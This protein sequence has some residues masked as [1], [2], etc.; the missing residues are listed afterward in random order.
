MASETRRKIF[1]NRNQSL[2][3]QSK[4]RIPTIYYWII[5]GLAILSWCLSGGFCGVS[6]H[7]ADVAIHQRNFEVAQL[8]LRFTKRLQPANPQAL[9]L[10]A[11]I[12]RL[13]DDFFSMGRLLD[14]AE[15]NGM[16]ADRVVLER[17]LS[18]AQNGLLEDVELKITERLSKGDRDLPEICEAYA[19]GLAKESRFEAAL[20]ILNAWRA[21]QPDTPIP[22]YRIARIEEYLQQLDHAKS[23][24][25]SAILKNKNYFPA[26]FGLA[27]LCLDENDANESLELYKQ[28]L[29]MPK[30][31]AARIGMAMSYI[32]LGNLELAKLL[33]E[34]VVKLGSNTVRLSY[35]SVGEPYERFIAASELGKLL[36]NEGKFAQALGFLDLALSEN[37]R[38][39][40]ARYSKA[41]A[42]R[43][44]KRDREA[45]IEFESVSK[46]REALQKVSSLS[47][48]INRFSSDV[49]S[50]IELGKLLVQYE[51]ERTGL[52]WLRSALIYGEDS[53]TVH[54]ALAEFYESHLLTEP[55]NERLAK[56]HRE[57]FLILQNKQN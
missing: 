33:L 17:Q 46:T 35:T 16:E 1:V 6:N 13:Q 57:R 41:I 24:Y 48:K 51:S 14:A 5:F 49:G 7:F 30:P 40:S 20:K 37:P 56:F 3:S 27:R 44:L 32:K 22:L 47:D 36:S 4:R 31:A 55:G 28:C 38:D 23:N 39:V 45:E 29:R 12:A 11:R 54:E 53:A 19:N 52:F 25:Q 15:R 43:G 9:F 18:L 42:L 50:R 34:E 2:L 10:A 21:D 26:I 8:W